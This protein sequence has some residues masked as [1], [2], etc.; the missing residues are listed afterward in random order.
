M[1]EINELFE[2]IETIGNGRTWRNNNTNEISNSENT[3]YRLP[4]MYML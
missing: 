4:N 1:D 3:N 2:V